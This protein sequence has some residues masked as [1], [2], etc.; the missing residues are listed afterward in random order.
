MKKVLFYL[1]LLV[2]API[3]VLIIITPM[4]SQKQYIFGFISL[5]IMFV[6][7]FSKK[8]SVSIIMI[9]VDR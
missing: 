2:L 6:L 3:A 5:A 9:V 7:G 8:H 4:D 1:L